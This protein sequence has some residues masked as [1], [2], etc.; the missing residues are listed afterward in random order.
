MDKE[1]WILSLV[2]RYERPLCSYAYGLLRNLEW[3]RDAV[4]DS[5]LRLCGQKPAKLK[6]RE[7][8]W[9][10]RVCRNRSLDILR[11]EKPSE[12]LSESPE[13]VTDD[14]TPDQQTEQNDLIALL[15]RFLAKLSKNQQEVIRLK[16]QQQLSYREI[17]QCTQLSESN[18]GY[19]LHTGLK[20]LR[21]QMINL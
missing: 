9:L 17:A 21:E 7:A 14:P 13:T 18:V 15:P 2:R 11:K 8:P 5:F 12:P 20:T 3:A 10:F 16:F 19:L 4:Q 1:T 6:G